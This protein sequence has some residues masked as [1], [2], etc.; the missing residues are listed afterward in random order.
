M[1]KRIAAIGL[2]GLLAIACGSSASRETFDEQG[3]AADPGAGAAVTD[4]GQIGGQPAGE[5]PKADECTK[6]DLVFIVDDSGSMSEE[7]SNLASNFPKVVSILD[8]FKTKGGSKIDWRAAITTSGRDVAYTISAMGMTIPQN[9]KGDN[10]AFRNKS[11]C[12]S[13]KAWVEKADSNATQAF[14]CLAKVGTSG[15]SLEMPLYAMKLSLVDRVADGKNAGFLRPDALLAVIILTDEDDCSREDNNFTIANDQ[16]G[17]GANVKPVADYAMMLDGVAGG[18]GRWATAVIAGE[19][20]CKS[21]F[22]DA[23]EAKRL[24][25]FVTLA[26]PNGKFSSICAGDLTTALTDA[27]ATFDGACRNFPGPR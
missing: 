21:S 27:L 4:P 20:S 3:P 24:K 10:G 8:S 16:C 19:K 1:H 22:G 17:D 15:P 18:P 7:Q 2:V 13:T 9:E 12:G 25:D 11:S 23:A 5:N 26:G 14:S 6:M